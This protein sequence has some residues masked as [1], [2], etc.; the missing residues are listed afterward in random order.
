[1]PPRYNVPGGILRS[2]PA[3]HQASEIDDLG[4]RKT[5]AREQGS[6][7][8]KPLRAI[9]HEAAHPA[10]CRRTH[11]FE[12]AARCAIPMRCALASLWESG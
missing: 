3:I 8:R 5:Q 6:E 10:W 7:P 2:E 4:L 9:G 1:M 12:P 11:S